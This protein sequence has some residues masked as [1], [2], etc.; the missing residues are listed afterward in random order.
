MRKP[1]RPKSRSLTLS[2]AI[3]ARRRSE[4]NVSSTTRVIADGERRRRR[5]LQLERRREPF[6]GDGGAA[7][8]AAGI[9]APS[10]IEEIADDPVVGRRREP[11]FPVIE[12]DRHRSRAERLG[13]GV[14]IAEVAQEG[15]D[16]R[17]VRPERLQVEAA[18]VGGELPPA[19]G[20]AA[21]R[22]LGGRAGDEFA[23][24]YDGARDG[25]SR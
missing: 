9:G 3:S 1:G 24:G 12:P 15:S 25:R 10:A 8:I 22:V 18:R 14:T 21:A 17:R 11:R 16:E 2:P 6:G 23:G 5:P 13:R 19:G 4:A 20:V 7:M